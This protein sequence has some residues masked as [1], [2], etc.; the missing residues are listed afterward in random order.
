MTLAMA[1][2]GMALARTRRV[3]RSNASGFTNACTLLVLAAGFSLTHG[4]WSGLHLQTLDFWSFMLI[5]AIV[6]HSIVWA[7][8]A[9]QLNKPELQQDFGDSFMLS[10]LF[11]DQS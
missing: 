7:A 9:F 8:V 10:M 6:A 11:A 4:A 3:R 2:A 5:V 1:L